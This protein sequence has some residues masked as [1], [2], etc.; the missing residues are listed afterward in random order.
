MKPS[1]QSSTL[2]KSLLIFQTCALLIYTVIVIRKEG[3]S[4]FQIIFNNIIDLSWNGQFNLDF[5]CYLALSGIWI[6]WRHKFSL[7]SILVA[8]PVMIIGIIAFAP[9][10]L[11]LLLKEKSDLKKVLLGEQIW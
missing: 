8:I 1:N 9:Y 11:Y 5:S 7:T 2:I 3:W 4:L 10:L 6:M